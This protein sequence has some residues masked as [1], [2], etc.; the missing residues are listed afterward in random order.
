[1]EHEPGA[2][3]PLGHLKV[4][5]LTRVLA[6][7]FATMILAD[8]G[9]TII[10]IERPGA[11]DD[12][13]EFGPFVNGESAYFMNINRNKKSLCLD[14]KQEKGKALFLE[15]IAGADVIVE[16]FRPGTMEKMGLGYETLKE[17]NPRLIYASI[18]GFGNS[19]PYS[20]RPAYDIIVQAMSGLMSITGPEG[21]EPIRVG[22]SMGDLVAALYGV[23]GILSALE[24]RNKTGEGQSVDIAM[25]DCQVSF[26]ENAIARY[27]VGGQ[28]PSPIGNRHPSIVPFESFR[29]ADSSLVIAVGND[30]LW[31]KFCACIGR[32]ELVSDPRF[33]TNPKRNE[34]HGQLKTLLDEV[35]SSRSTDDWIASLEA[36]G[37]PCS[38]IN[39]IHEVLEHPQLIARQMFVNVDH[40][41]A[42]P[43]T[44][45]GVP[46]KLSATPGSVR[47]PAPTLGQ[48]SE[49]ILKELGYG[50]GE[51]GNFTEQGVIALAE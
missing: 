37:I 11:G 3:L 16:N 14:L 22:V 19:G 36:A 30:A 23:I 10:K 21:G 24:N 1:M 26:L 17:K 39:R 46:I 32:P 43:S 48:H 34:N 27:L 33:A 42:G 15:L 50:D 31:A 47:E 49:E 51:I 38:P 41:K 28:D 44:V 40:P 45:I 35:F 18:S 13:R 2:N 8:M 12:S 4:I 25:L 6:G 20:T 5:D 29:T 7:P 9:A